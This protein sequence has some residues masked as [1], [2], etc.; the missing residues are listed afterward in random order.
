MPDSSFQGPSR[1]SSTCSRFLARAKAVDPDAWRRLVRL[2][3]PLVLY[4]CSEAGL[5]SPDRDDVSQDVF[6]AVAKNMR[7]FRGDRPS[8]T[9]RGWL[10]T[11]TRSKIADHCRRQINCQS[12]TGGSQAYEQLLNCRDSRKENRPETD[13]PREHSIVVKQA[14]RAIRSEFTDRTWQAFWRTAIDGL[15]S[16]VVAEQME[17]TPEAVRKA[18]SRVLRR[19]RHEL[20]EPPGWQ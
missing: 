5:R 19:L 6:L 8:D 17:M 2:Y 12:A 16:G 14:I 13:N 10:R 7:H 11:I 1:I 3:S 20:R 18:K 9:F 4:W 15:V